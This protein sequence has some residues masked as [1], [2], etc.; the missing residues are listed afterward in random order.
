MRAAY[1]ALDDATKLMLDDKVAL[2]QAGRT[3]DT[4]APSLVSDERRAR[5]AVRHAMVRA[6]PVNGRRVLYAGGHAGQRRRY[7][8]DSGITDWQ[9]EN[10]GPSGFNTTSHAPRVRGTRHRVMTTVVTQCRVDVDFESAIRWSYCA[11]RV[12]WRLRFR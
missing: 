6:N 11:A 10:S 3:R 9:R 7:N 1:A 12:L 2:H 5:P 8:R 4:T